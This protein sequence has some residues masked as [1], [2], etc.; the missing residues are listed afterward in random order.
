M[1]II[2]TTVGTSL[3]TN[4]KRK[5][6]DINNSA[7][8]LTCYLRDT[9]P[10][11]ASAETNSLSR[12]MQRDDSVVFIHSQTEEGKQC[13][14]V[15]EKHYRSLGYHSSSIEV[16]GLNYKEKQFKMQGMRSLVD[17]L[18]GQIKKAR[19]ENRMVSI[20]ATGGFKAE[21]AYATMVGLIFKV[22]VYYIHEMFKEVVEIPRI[23]LDWDYSLIADNE[24]FFVW[25]DSGIRLYEEAE[26]RLKAIDRNIEIRMLLIHEDD[27]T[28]LSPA[29][30]ALFRA[31]TIEIDRAKQ[32]P[33]FLSDSALK[34]YNQ[35]EPVTKN[36]FHKQFD[37]LRMPN[38]RKPN[39]HQE[40]QCDVFLFPSGRYNERIFYTEEDGHLKIYELAIHDERY[41][42]L[43][44]KGVNRGNY[45]EHDFKILEVR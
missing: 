20:N 40:P 18:I 25:I 26:Q 30:D 27:C 2:L 31:F 7:E 37:R 4:A 17:V 39:T 45:P 34:Y 32:I 6:P 22:P 1:T 28:Y 15:L 12:L 10:E 5:N 43:I 16:S 24:E 3:M 41:D 19:E 36:A 13:A 29:G 35:M 21:T 33:L 42:R 23:P 9:K 11:D 8:Y 38:I 44:K 14:T